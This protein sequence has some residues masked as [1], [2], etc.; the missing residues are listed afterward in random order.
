MCSNIL[1]PP[2]T[3]VSSLITLTDAFTK[4][5]SAYLQELAQAW[6]FLCLLFA[7]GRLRPGGPYSFYSPPP[8]TLLFK[9]PLALESPTPSSE[10]VTRETLTT[11]LR[12]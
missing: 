4:K 3:V 10:R 6:L 1:K 2:N 11:P 8:H 5:V 9:A 12:S 7:A